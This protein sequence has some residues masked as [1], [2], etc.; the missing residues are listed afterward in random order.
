MR[1]LFTKIA[2]YLLPSLL[3][4]S[5]CAYKPGPVSNHLTAEQQGTI[6]FA[7]NDGYDFNAYH[8]D[9]ALIVEGD[10]TIPQPHNGKAV[11]LSHGSGGIRDYHRNWQDFLNRNGYATFMLD[12]FRPRNTL[13]VLHSQVRVTEQQMA[14][15]ILHAYQLLQTHP[16]IKSTDIFHMGWSKGASAGMLAALSK[17]EAL[18]YGI[19][20]DVNDNK[21]AG[22]IEFYPWCGVRGKLQISAP[23]RIFHGDED[24][25]TLLSACQQFVEDLQTAGGDI[26]IIVL[27]GAKHGFDAWDNPVE[28]LPRSVTVREASQ[29]CTLKIDPQT[30]EITSLDGVHRV[31]NYETRKQFL[32]ACAERGVSVGGSAQHKDDTE[33]RVLEV[34]HG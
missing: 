4:L 19:A 16:Q 21:I 11:I 18:V 26:E 28:H 6:W 13:N 1:D 3:L 31:D 15:D 5:A 32:I 23:V 22:F 12:H 7:S 2:I 27:Q 8:P 20:S 25:Y 34:L 9:L 10:L 14:F 33:K 29:P 17:V 24:D 30:L